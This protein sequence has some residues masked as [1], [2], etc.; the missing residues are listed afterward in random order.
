[1]N[2]IAGA[3]P[4]HT[5]T[6]YHLYMNRTGLITNATLTISATAKTTF[7]VKRKNAFTFIKCNCVIIMKRC[8]EH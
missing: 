1:M 3:V 8:L 7:E 4:T 6:E 5:V 2:S